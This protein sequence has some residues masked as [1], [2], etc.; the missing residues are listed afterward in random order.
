MMMGLTHFYYY[1][2]YK[3]DVPLQSGGTILIETNET[4]VKEVSSTLYVDNCTPNDEGLFKAVIQN[5]AGE[6]HHTATLKVIS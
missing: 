6:L 4:K 5:T 1:F 2:R 3:E